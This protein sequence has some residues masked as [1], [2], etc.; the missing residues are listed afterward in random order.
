MVEEPFSYVVVDCVGPLPKTLEG[1]QH[2]LII[3]CPST[4]FSEAVHLQNIKTP[5]IVKALMKFFMFFGLPHFFSQIKVSVLC[6]ASF[7]ST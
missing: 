7:K 1:S 6:L 5:K 2:P 3:M 4:R